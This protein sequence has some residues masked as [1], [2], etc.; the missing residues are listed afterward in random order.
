[1]KQEK[2]SSF[3][4]EL[5]FT[6]RDHGAIIVKRAPVGIPQEV[7]EFF[8]KTDRYSAL[9]LCVN[10]MVIVSLSEVSGLKRDSYRVI[11]YDEVRASK[12]K[13]ADGGMTRRIV[14]SLDDELLDLNAQHESTSGVRTSGLWGAW[15]A[16]NL[17]AVSQ[18][19]ETLGTPAQE[20]Q[21]RPV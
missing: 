17:P 8:T 2:L 12:V 6:M 3:V 14:I 11:A 13:I 19:I 4:H 15:H 16:Q 10:E 9:C 1:M 7:I 20:A 18:F 21:T 5:G